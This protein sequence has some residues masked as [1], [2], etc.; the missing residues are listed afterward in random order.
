MT[1]LIIHSAHPTIHI[2]STIHVP[3]RCLVSW[4]KASSQVP[5][6]K[7]IKS[8]FNPLP[9]RWF[10][11]RL[12]ESAF[13]PTPAWKPV[14]RADVGAET[15]FHG[16]N[17]DSNNLLK[18]PPMQEQAQRR[19]AT[20]RLGWCHTSAWPAT[21]CSFTPHLL[22]RFRDASWVCGE[23]SF[24]TRNDRN[25]RNYSIYTQKWQ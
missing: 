19:A 25:D 2:Q 14:S 10:L 24:K 8:K 22:V 3:C 20:S 9:M 7:K 5:C 4:P 21:Q 23:N 16:W 18:F 11:K 17:A 15:G 13:Q 1:K 6:E 12:F